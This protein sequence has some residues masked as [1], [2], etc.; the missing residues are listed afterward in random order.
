MRI[1]RSTGGYD[2]GRK[3]RG[4]QSIITDDEQENY[5]GRPIYVFSTLCFKLAICISYLRLTRGS[6]KE[7]AR[8]AIWSGLVF[9]ALYNVTYIFTLLFACSPV[10]ASWDYSI[11]GKCLAMAPYYY[12]TGV[13]T[14]VNDLVLFILPV[15]L[16]W[17]LQVDKRTKIGLSVMFLLGL[18]TTFCS[19][20]RIV[21]ITYIKETGNTTNFIL[22]GVVEACVGVSPAM[23]SQTPPKQTLTA[24]ADHDIFNTS[25]STAATQPE[26]ES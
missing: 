13:L 19:I 14:M 25:P 5:A 1:C 23:R 4:C 16:V 21:A 12:T 9:T 24:V 20:M 26:Q 11:D 3:S 7:T 10:A 8:L 2:H 22:W 6:H 15:P 17:R 18:I